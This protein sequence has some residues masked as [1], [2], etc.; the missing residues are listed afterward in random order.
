[1]K[2]ILSSP[3]TWAEVHLDI[4]ESGEKSYGREGEAGV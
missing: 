3:P 4:N 2:I 1:M